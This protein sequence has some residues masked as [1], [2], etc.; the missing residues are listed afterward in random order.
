MELEMTELFDEGENGLW[1]ATFINEFRHTPSDGAVNTK[2]RVYVQAT[3]TDSV[4]SIED[5][6]RA[7]LARYLK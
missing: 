4:Q 1:R 2:F 6:A 5:R 7:A 3:K